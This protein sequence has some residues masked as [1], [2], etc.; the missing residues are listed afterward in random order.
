[1]A[2]SVRHLSRETSVK[3]TVTTA[4]GMLSRKIPRHD[5]ASTMAPPTTGPATV[6]ALVQAVHEPIALPASSLYVARSSARLP[7]VSK[8]PKTPWIARAAISTS[9]VGAS[10][11][12]PRR[13]RSRPRR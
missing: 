2:S 1:M 9:L 12:A 6:A 4:T 10:R 5:T 7:G 8:A 11:R 13:L 3:T